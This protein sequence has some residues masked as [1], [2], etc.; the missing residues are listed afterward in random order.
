MQDRI[1]PPLASIRPRWANRLARRRGWL[2]G[3]IAVAAVA[4]IPAAAGFAQGEAAPFTVVETGQGYGRLQQAV[5]AIGNGKGSIAIAPGV[6]RQ[7]AVQ[8]AGSIAFLA[9]EP[10]QAILDAVTCEGKAALVLRG[11]EAS[12]SGLVFRNMAV[13]DFNGAGIRLEAGNLTVANSWFIDSQQGILTAHDAGIT[14][15]VDRSTFAGLGTCDGAGGC[16]HSIYTGTIGRLRV[17]RSRFERGTGGHYVKSRARVT[18]VASS[19]FDDS[20]GHATNYMI[21]LPQGSVGQITNNWFVQGRDKENYSAFIAVA[22]EEGD[23]PSAG[24]VIAGN[25]ARFVPGLQ[26]NSVFIADWSGARLVIEDNDL[27]PG[28]K[29][30]ERR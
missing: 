10:G 8:Q 14:L 22:A 12:V 27:G 15:I 21:D 23:Q 24:L 7:C 3:A 19:S 28:L 4:L 9:S 1:R 18:E 11:R 5:D 30:F 29:L 6:H 13:A 16:A 20:A 25:D 2:A 17:T 26:R